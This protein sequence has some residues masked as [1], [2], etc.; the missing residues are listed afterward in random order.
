MKQL[1]TLELNEHCQCQEC[2]CTISNS[3]TD[4][5]HEVGEIR[6]N[7]L[8]ETCRIPCVC[9]RCGDQ[10]QSKT[11]TFKQC[12]ASLALAVNRLDVKCTDQLTNSQG[13]VYELVY[14]IEFDMNL[15]TILNVY[16]RQDSE[17]VKVDGT[18]VS[19]R[20]STITSQGKFL[21]LW[22][23]RSNVSTHP[24]P[25]LSPPQSASS[26][27]QIVT[28]PNDISTS[29]YQTQSVISFDEMFDITTNTASETITNPSPTTSVTEDDDDAF[30]NTI[31]NTQSTSVVSDDLS[32][33]NQDSVSDLYLTLLHSTTKD[34][35]AIKTRTDHDR[36]VNTLTSELV[37]P[38][39]VDKTNQRTSKKSSSSTTT[40]VH[41]ISSN[42]SRSLKQLPNR[43]KSHR[44]HPYTTA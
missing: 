28:N 19:T 36:L 17:F 7:L 11:V 37:W 40:T 14:I 41:S 1:F 22:L 9:F 4:V 10:N 38:L 2:D 8:T 30:W 31:A 24:E 13:V 18:D 39:I 43:V 23:S 32:T 35:S 16:L 34:S 12:N 6:A 44:S 29:S 27:S 33:T 3:I 21:T 42:S 15:K 25:Y 20:L 5:I 26:S